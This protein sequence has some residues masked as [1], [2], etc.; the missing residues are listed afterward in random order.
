MIDVIYLS[1]SEPLS[2]KKFYVIGLHTVYFQ[3][4]CIY[5][6]GRLPYL[7]CQYYHFM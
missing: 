4:K 5:G 3:C 1:V 7:T 6:I 2:I